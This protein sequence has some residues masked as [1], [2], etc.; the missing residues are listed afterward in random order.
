VFLTHI[1]RRAGAQHWYSRSVF[2]SLAGVVRRK[3]ECRSGVRVARRLS[4]RDFFS[5]FLEKQR[6]QPH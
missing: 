2:S 1:D 4:T 3:T 5:P 6:K